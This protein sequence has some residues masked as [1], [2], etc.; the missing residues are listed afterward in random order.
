MLRRTVF[1]SGAAIAGALLATQ[2][3][4]IARY[5]RIERMSFGD[6]NPDGVPV[7][8]RHRYPESSAGGAPDGTGDFDSASRGG[9]A[10]NS[11]GW[12]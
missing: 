2:W 7:T 6:G 9:P 1:L 4:D 5:A 10:P 11:L 3:K 8:G 12:R